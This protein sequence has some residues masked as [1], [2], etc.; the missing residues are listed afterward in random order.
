MR[1]PL[2]LTV[3]FVWPR[4]T[5]VTMR[6]NYTSVLYL[7]ATVALVSMRTTRPGVYASENQANYALLYP[8]TIC[9]KALTKWHTSSQYKAATLSTLPEDGICP[10]IQPSYLWE[11][12]RHCIQWLNGVCDV[13]SDS[14]AQD[15]VGTKVV[16]GVIRNP[17]RPAFSLLQLLGPN[18]KDTV[19][20]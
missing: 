2:G 8:C 12:P 15:R 5:P 19:P 20:C 17:F 16:Q 4:L 3:G 18:R 10:D 7:I 6:L 11:K 9:K 1:P 14:G 13:W